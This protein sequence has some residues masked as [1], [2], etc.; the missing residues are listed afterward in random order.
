[1]QKISSFTALKMSE[2]KCLSN[3][4]LKE[5]KTERKMFFFNYMYITCIRILKMLSPY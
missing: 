3:E 5:K 4:I 2:G 1:M